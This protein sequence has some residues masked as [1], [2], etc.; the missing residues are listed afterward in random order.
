MAPDVPFSPSSYSYTSGAQA[1]E[2]T[3][4]SNGKENIH[5]V[6]RIRPDIENHQAG[7]ST[8]KCVFAD[9]D[10]KHISIVRE[11]GEVKR[12]KFD[13]VFGPQATQTEMFSIA[14]RFVDAAMKGYNG[15]IFAVS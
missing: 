14:R 13:G 8:T 12:F 4:S 7:A 5:T 3:T 2:P 9:G 6:V 11:G 15:T 1:A 10:G